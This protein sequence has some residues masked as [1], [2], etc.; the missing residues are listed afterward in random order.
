MKVVWLRLRV[1]PLRLIRVKTVN[2]GMRFLLPI[3]IL[4]LLLSC[5]TQEVTPTR[6]DYY[7]LKIGFWQSY[8]VTGVDW[9]NNQA[10]PFDYELKTEITDSFVS[11]SG[12]DRFVI[13]RYTRPT[14]FF[15]WTYLDTW[16]AW[17]D[18]HGLQLAEGNVIYK[19]IRLPVAVGGVWNSNEFNSKEPDEYLLKSEGE[20]FARFGDCIRVLEEDDYTFFANDDYRESFYASGVGLVYKYVKHR[21]YCT[22]AD[23]PCYNTGY[24]EEGHEEEIQIVGFSQLE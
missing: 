24:I 15:T 22:D 18:D 1:A 5:E 12:E 3:V 8:R 10:T 4:L 6:P 17:A 7:P 19:K 2:C 14:G 21:K 13:S 11:G 16:S 23:L 20:S 9:Y